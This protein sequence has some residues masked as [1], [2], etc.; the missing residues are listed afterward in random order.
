MSLAVAIDIGGTFT[1]LVAFD[2]DSKNV[3]YAKSP[4]TYG[5]FVAGILKCFD[6]AGISPGDADLVNHG[7]GGATRLWRHHRCRWQGETPLMILVHRALALFGRGQLVDLV[8]LMASYA[9]TAALLTAFDMQLPPGR[10]P[11]LP[12][13]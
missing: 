4:T 2:H 3:V 6:S 5:N 9:G 13:E 1:D 10:E 12:M 7:G 8:S 11:P